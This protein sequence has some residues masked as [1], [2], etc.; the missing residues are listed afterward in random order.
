M[1]V[2]AQVV[3]GLRDFLDNLAPA[4]ALFDVAEQRSSCGC[5]VPERGELDQLVGWRRRG[6]G[7]PSY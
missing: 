3:G 1:D 2:R 4:L 7:E 5:R 6:C